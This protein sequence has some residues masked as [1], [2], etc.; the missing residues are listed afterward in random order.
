MVTAASLPKVKSAIIRLASSVF[1]VLSLT[2]MSTAQNTTGP[3]INNQGIV[4]QGQIGNNT[5]NQAPPP[6]LREVPL[7]RGVESVKQE[8]DGSYTLRTMVE[9]VAP[10]P[11]GQL[12]IKASAPGI[13]DMD[14][15][16]QR[17]G[18]S[19]TGPSGVRESF[20]FTTLMSPFG[21]YIIAVH[22]KN[23]AT[24]N[25]EYGF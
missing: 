11:P 24:V 4:T 23:P 15:I 22:L 7:P 18:M 10:Y 9:I 16:P 2:E 3:I 19:Q 14:V 20:A 17:S 12:Q 21:K 25:L 1:V 13:I 5:I 6:E 8:S